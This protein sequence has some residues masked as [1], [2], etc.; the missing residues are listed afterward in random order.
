VD[1]I[2]RA[3]QIAVLAAVISLVRLLFAISG[4]AFVQFTQPL[5]GAGHFD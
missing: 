1:R 3:M 5:T 2:R 4:M